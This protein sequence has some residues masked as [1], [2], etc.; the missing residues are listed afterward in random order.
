MKTIVEL[1]EQDYTTAQK[2]TI[3]MI[4]DAK[5]TLSL[6]SH[7]L[8]YINNKLERLQQKNTT[9][10]IQTNEQQ[11]TNNASLLPAE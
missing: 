1:T 10:T 3:A 2:Q 6:L 8:V 9:T 11:T 7:Q 5:L 4:R